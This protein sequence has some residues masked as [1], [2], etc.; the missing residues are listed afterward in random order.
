MNDYLSKPF[1]PTQLFEKL[2]SFGQRAATNSR[3]VLANDNAAT[4]GRSKNDSTNIENENTVFNYNPRLD[5][6]LLYD[7]YGDDMD[8]ARE[9]FDTFLKKSLPEVALLKR[10]LTTENW[11]ELGRLAHKLKPSFGMV[12]LKDLEDKMQGIED[13]AKGYPSYG[14]LYDLLTDFEKVLPQAID[15]VESDLKKLKE[16]MK[17]AL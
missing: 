11:T 12:G 4:E 1:K 5:K 15:A 16:N 8:Y 3:N 10:Q 6:N 17:C 14:G 13:M 7:L 9:M 2:Q